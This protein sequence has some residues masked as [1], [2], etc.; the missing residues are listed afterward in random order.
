VD[1]EAIR[2]RIREDHYLIKADAILHAIKEGFDR[3]NMVHAVLT[4]RVIEEYSERKRVLV[5]GRTVLQ[6]EGLEIYLHVVC[7][8][9]DPVYVELVTA[10]IPDEVT[11]DK[12]PFRRRKHR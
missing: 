4:G 3:A 6:P 11:W 9:R 7:E 12:P 10:Y 5:C 8:H 1:I 2:R